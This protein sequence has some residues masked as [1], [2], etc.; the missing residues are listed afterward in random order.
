MRPRRS[1]GS[2]SAPRSLPRLADP[3]SHGIE[4]GDKS[5]SAKGLARYLN[6]TGARYLSGCC[7]GTVTPRGFLRDAVDEAALGTAI[8]ESPVVDFVMTDLEN[9]EPFMDLHGSIVDVTAPPQCSR[10]TVARRPRS[11]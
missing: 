5:G 8:I 1:S 7:R 11:W 2:C 6:T 10:S 9:E 3:A 4:P